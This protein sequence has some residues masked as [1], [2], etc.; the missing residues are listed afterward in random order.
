VNQPPN[1]SKTKKSSR[2]FWIALALAAQFV[3]A[4]AGPF[5]GEFT[6]AWTSNSSLHA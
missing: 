3:F 4:V 2:P 5:S 6:E 1:S